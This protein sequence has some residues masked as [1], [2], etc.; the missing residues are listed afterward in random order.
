MMS[1]Q[2]IRDYSLSQTTLDDVFIYFASQ[3]TEEEREEERPS[4]GG[5]RDREDGDTHSVPLPDVVAHS[6]GVCCDS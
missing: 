6:R 5:E 1:L 3:Q 2:E 4:G